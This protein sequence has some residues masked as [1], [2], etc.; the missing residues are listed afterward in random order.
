M[1]I[2]AYHTSKHL[3]WEFDE[4]K[5]DSSGDWSFFIEKYFASKALYFSERPIPYYPNNFVYK[6]EL[7]IK[8]PYITSQ[9]VI[10]TNCDGIIVDN[11]KFNNGANYGEIIAPSGKQVKILAIACNKYFSKYNE[12]HTWKEGVGFDQS[13]YELFLKEFERDCIL[14]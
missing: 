2:I 1:K 14:L 5:W 11:D 10:P 4:K 7:D 6:V 3:F 8:T 9:K 12:I 13:W